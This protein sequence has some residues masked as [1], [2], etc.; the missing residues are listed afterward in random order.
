MEL[1]SMMLGRFAYALV[2]FSLCFGQ[3]LDT[4]SDC[5]KKARSQPDMQVCADNEFRQEE[6]AMERTYQQLLVKAKSD[7]VAEKK[8]G[9]AQQSWLA[10]RHAQ[11]EAMYP[12]EDK[13]G[14]YGTAYPMC[15]LFL[16]TELTRQRTQMLIKML[17]PVEGDVCDAGLR[18]SNCAA[19]ARNSEC[20]PYQEK[21]P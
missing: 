3:Q 6:A 17:N 8:I 11:L 12:H 13:Q 21:L 2:T 4:F 5:R 1:R 19:Q 10:F 15:A 16:E 7:P 9:A 18:Y 14:E 20:S